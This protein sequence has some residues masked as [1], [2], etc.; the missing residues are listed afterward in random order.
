MYAKMDGGVIMKALIFL[1]FNVHLA[2]SHSLQYFYTAVTPGINFPEF[3][4]VGLVDGEQFV[5]Y[6]NIIRKM[7]PKTEWI[8]KSE[9][10]DYWSRQTQTLQGN[11]ESFKVGIG[12]LMERFNETKGENKHTQYMND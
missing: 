3:T 1:A 12:T 4:I 2:G 11:Q 9:G 7:I 5:Y 8:E 10:A 6:D